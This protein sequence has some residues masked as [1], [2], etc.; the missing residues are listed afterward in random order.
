MMKKWINSVKMLKYGYRFKVSCIFAVLL[1]LIGFAIC[2]LDKTMFYL[3]GFYIFLSTSMIL[4]IAHILLTSDVIASSSCRRWLETTFQDISQ[5]VFG[6]VAYLCVVLITVLKKVFESSDMEVTE[7]FG[8]Q[9]IM[10]GA[11]IGVLIIYESVA[12]KYFVASVIAI[13]AVY[14]VIPRIFILDKMIDIVNGTWIGYLFILAGVLLAT[15]LRRALYKKPYSN[16]LVCSW[17]KKQ[18]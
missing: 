9:L 1:A 2:I 13:S 5:I 6:S 15:I 18:M 7:S 10:S 4:Q 14:G 16:Y 12:Y 17:A 8:N 11:M 3:G